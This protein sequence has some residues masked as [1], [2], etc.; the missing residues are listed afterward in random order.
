MKIYFS[1]R[2]FTNNKIK[3]KPLTLDNSMLKGKIGELNKTDIPSVK[4]ILKN[5]FICT[6]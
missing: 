4:K 6:L 1:E 5:L 3:F 2:V